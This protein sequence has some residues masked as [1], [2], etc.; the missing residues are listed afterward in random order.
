MTLDVL[1]SGPSGGS[2]FISPDLGAAAT[3]TK[4][5]YSV[6]MTGAGGGT[7]DGVQRRRSGLSTGYHAWA[8]P[9][10]TSTG[11]RYFGTNTTGT[12]WQSNTSLAQRHDRHRHA[13]GRLRHPVSVAIGKKG[14]RSIPSSF[15]VSQ[16]FD[17]RGSRAGGPSLHGRYLRCDVHPHGAGGPLLAA[18][19][20]RSRDHSRRRHVHA[21]PTVSS[22]AISRW[23]FD[24][25]SCSFAT[26]CSRGRF[27]SGIPIRPTGSRRSTTRSISCFICHRC[28]IRL[29]LPEVLAYNLWVALPVPLAAWGTYLFLRRHVSPPAAAFGAV[30]FGAAGPMVSTTNFPNMSWSVAAVPYVFWALERVK[31]AADGARSDAAGCGRR[32]S[33][34]RRRAGDAGRDAGDCRRLCR[35][36]SIAAGRSVAWSSPSALGL[37]RRRSA[38]RDSVRAARRGQPRVGARSRCGRDD[39]W[40]FHPLALTELVVPHFFGDYFTSHLRQLGVDGGAQ[41]PT[42]T[43]LLLDVCRRADRA[44][45]GVAAFSGRPTHGVL[46]DRARRLPARL[47]RSA[48]RPSIPLCETLVPPLRSFRFPVKYLSLGSFGLAVLAGFAIQWLIDRDVPRRPLTW[49]LAAACTLSVVTYAFV[50]WLLA[51][52]AI[53][54]H[55]AYR[56][57][58]PYARAVS[59]ARC[60]VSD[61]PRAPVADDALPE[62]GVLGVPAVD[63]G[64]AA[65]RASHG[66]HRLRGV[67][68][69]GS[70]AGQLRRQS[71]APGR[72][73]REAGMD[74]AARSRERTSASTS[75]DGSLAEIDSRDIDAPKYS[76]GFDERSDMERRYMHRERARLP[77]VRVADSRADVVRSAGAVADRVRADA[78]AVPAGRIARSGSGS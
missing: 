19:R 29:L 31:A 23:P 56:L 78:D 28:S 12:I 67:C 37:D 48:T 14:C 55:L 7:G 51:A 75:A 74:A 60:G 35:R 11:T 5:G 42:R 50:A 61:F 65:T 3:A 58:H 40:A 18:G 2:A 4:S 17:I 44:G 77:H 46:D 57:A 68:R 62:A 54:L 1:G 22:C 59:L 45:R 39:F 47:V 15:E 38:G 49:V 30:A 20:A 13:V 33:G 64:L 26:A 43:V 70:G 9:V 76:T 21:E 32:L 69:R 63:R 71:D 34:A 36:A 16:R 6:S 25:A 24:P 72:L 41:Q 8:D 52:P 66:A 27:R 53:P 73:G 10:S